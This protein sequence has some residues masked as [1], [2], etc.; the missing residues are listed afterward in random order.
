MN[1]HGVEP[2]ALDA[3]V[4]EEEHRLEHRGEDVRIPVVEVPLVVVEGRPDPGVELLDP[5]EV[6]RRGVGKDVPERLLVR[7]REG[8]VGEREVVAAIRLVAAAGACRPGVLGRGVVHDEVEA[9]AHATAPKLRREPLEAVH[10]AEARIDCA[11]VGDG[12][13][14][15]VRA[16]PRLEQR[17]Q[18][19]V[20]HPELLEVVEALGDAGEG[21]REPVDVADV[22]DESLAAEPVG[23]ALAPLVE[24]PQV[25]RPGS[26]GLG[27]DPEQAVEQRV[28]VV[29]GAVEAPDE[30]P[31]RRQP[32]LDPRG[33]DVGACSRA[34][35][36]AP[37]TMMAVH[38]CATSD[39]ST[40]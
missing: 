24:R 6:P 7:V 8:S 23:N 30:R 38:A 25:V 10:V 2:E 19:Q 28:D 14:A 1:G 36:G 13:A 33:E 27:D 9:Q 31:G 40:T 4:G 32:A 15:V 17:H 18:V 5:R 34:A 29:L 16:G 11:V 39:P 35:H 37:V 26:G 22:P 3:P 21:V 12:V 20:A